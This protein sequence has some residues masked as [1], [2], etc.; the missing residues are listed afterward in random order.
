MNIGGSK[1]LNFDD[2]EYYPNDWIIIDNKIL[3]FGFMKIN[4][5]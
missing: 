5:L 3:V 1:N 2:K 4:K